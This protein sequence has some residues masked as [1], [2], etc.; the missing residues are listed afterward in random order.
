[1]IYRTIALKDL[2]DKFGK[3]TTNEVLSKFPCPLNKDVE[4]IVQQKAVP[5]ERAGMARTYL[6]IAQESKVTYGIYAVFN[7][8]KIYY[9]L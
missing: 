9:Y 7:D 6:I 3:E 1:M 8:N 2:I 4:K 5:Y